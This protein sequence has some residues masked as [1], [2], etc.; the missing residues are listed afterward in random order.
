MAT[1]NRQS[2]LPQG[3][4][5]FI[6]PRGPQLSELPPPGE[7][8][9]ATDIP[10]EIHN[11]LQRLRHLGVITVVDDVGTNDYETTE[12]G[13][14][15]IQDYADREDALLCGHGGIKNLGNGVYTCGSDQCDHRYTRDTMELLLLNDTLRE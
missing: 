6:R 4:E 15:V 11:T 2:R 12:Q 14:D 3:A 5:D 1:P 7:H 13:W 8:W 10:E 9:Q